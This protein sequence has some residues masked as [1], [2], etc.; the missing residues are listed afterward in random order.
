MKRLFGEWD[1]DRNGSLDQKELA[2]GL[3]KLVP[4][5]KGGFGGFGGPPKGGFGGFGG[6]PKFG[7][8]APSKG[9]FPPGKPPES[10]MPRPLAP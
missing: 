7:P 1:L 9:G 3:Q 10:P 4:P 6:P 8:G 2:D 5:P